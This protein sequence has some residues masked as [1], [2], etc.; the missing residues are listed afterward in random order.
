M[1]ITT[2][3]R[4]SEVE[5]IEVVFIFFLFFFYAFLLVCLCYYSAL[6]YLFYHHI[7]NFSRLRFWR[8]GGWSAALIE[9]VQKFPQQFGFW[10]E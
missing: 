7:K 1:Y 4:Q 3:L 8:G 9:G 6:S 2:N 5:R 10:T